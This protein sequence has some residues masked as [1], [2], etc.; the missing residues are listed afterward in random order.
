MNILQFIFYLG[1]IY[2]I[3]SFVWKWVFVLPSAIVLT[4]IKFDYG[5]R[6]V[7]IFGTYLLVSLTALLTLGALGQDPGILAI[8]FYPLIGASVLFFSYASN[9]YEARKEAYQTY[10]FNLIRI[11]ERDAI[12]EMFLTI[13]A[14]LLYLFVL[15]VPSISMNW[16]TYKAFAVVDWA[17]SLPII[18]WVIGIFGIFFL[19]NTILHSIFA[20]GF[21]GVAT[22]GRFKKE[23]SMGNA[24]DAVASDTPT[25]TP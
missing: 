4:L 15:F 25:P 13:G 2:I 12:F 17:Y 18:G 7:K 10:D 20:I 9:Q 5:M 22:F 19:L 23:E 8:I 21:L 14:V 1:V 24:L 3:F 16:M 11:L 6:F